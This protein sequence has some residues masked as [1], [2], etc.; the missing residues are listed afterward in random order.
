MDLIPCSFEFDLKKE[1]SKKKTKTKQKQTKKNARHP[2]SKKVVE[3]NQTIIFLGLTVSLI[4]ICKTN[5]TADKFQNLLCEAIP[6][7][8]KLIMRWTF[9]VRNA[10]VQ[11]KR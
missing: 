2:Y 9:M 10:S 6:E 8:V 7:S 5:W 1:T 3:D 11:N 4:T